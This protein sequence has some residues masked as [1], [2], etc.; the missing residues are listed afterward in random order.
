MSTTRGDSVTQHAHT[1]HGVAATAVGSS[2]GTAQACGDVTPVRVE[3]RGVG[4]SSAA[5]AAAVDAAAA[6]AAALAKSH[7]KALG[8]GNGGGSARQA[9]RAKERGVEQKRAALTATTSISPPH[10]V[11]VDAVQLSFVIYHFDYS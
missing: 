1:R 8:C 11:S 10:R 3:K 2:S 7:L 5:V 6:A 9:S 4:D